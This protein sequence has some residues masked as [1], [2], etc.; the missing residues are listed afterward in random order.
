M[1]WVVL[2]CLNASAHAS[3]ATGVS[4]EA[5]EATRPSGRNS[6]WA[7]IVRD[8]G[9]TVELLIYSKESTTNYRAQNYL[10]FTVEIPLLPQ[11][12]AN[13]PEGETRGKEFPTQTHKRVSD[14][15]LKLKCI[16]LVSCGNSDVLIVTI[17]LINICF[18]SRQMCSLANNF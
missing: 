17:N 12:G 6:T 16:K 2:A 5:G 3:G 7:D 9:N 1:A 18:S 15:S 14:M 11:T 13:L 8:S 4:S 10:Q